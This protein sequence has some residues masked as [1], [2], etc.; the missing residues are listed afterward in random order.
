[1]EQSGANA[2]Y[3]VCIVNHEGAAVLPATLAA[4]R[5]LAP[6]P[7]EVVLVDNASGDDSIALAV[8]MTGPTHEIRQVNLGD[9]KR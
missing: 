7:A 5:A 2:P 9:L 8:S 1:M 3:S 6:P 4:V